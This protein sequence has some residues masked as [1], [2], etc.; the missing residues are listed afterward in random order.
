M[1]F[2]LGGRT[3]EFSYCWWWIYGM[4]RDIWEVSYVYKHF[5][6]RERCYVG[7]AAVGVED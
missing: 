3:G 4:E 2:R 7:S 1:C 5:H 6:L